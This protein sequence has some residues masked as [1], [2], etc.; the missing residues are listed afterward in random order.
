VL[1]LQTLSAKFSV[2]KHN[3]DVYQKRRVKE[4]YPLNSKMF[5]NFNLFTCS[6]IIQ[7]LT[8]QRK[9]NIPKGKITQLFK[10]IFAT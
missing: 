3:L 5:R 7:L 8:V 1:I 6:S 9:E 2:S 4:Y 10:N